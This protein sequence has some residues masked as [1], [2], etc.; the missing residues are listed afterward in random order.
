MYKN[1]KIAALVPAYNEERLIAKTIMGMPDFV[2]H[3]IVVDD[4]SKDKTSEAAKKTKHKHLV[5]IRHEKNTGLGGAIRT[6]VKKA[7]ELGA[8]IGVVMAGDNQM[9]PAYLPSLLDPI[10][11]EG[12][13]FTKQNRFYATEGF[14]NM[15]RHRVFGS[16]MLAFMTR[17][18]S[19]YWHIIDPQNGYVAYGPKVLEELNFEKI[20]NGYAL[21]NDV[22][23]NLNILGMRI[24]EVPGKIVYADEQSDM[25]LWKIVPSFTLF[26]FLG[27]FRRV[28]KKYVLRGF[29]PIAIFYFFGSILFWF[30]LIFGLWAWRKAHLAGV[31]A[32]TGTVMLAALP[33]LMGFEMLLWGLVLDIQ[34]EPR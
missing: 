22:L 5:L 4:Q 25:N 15:P 23:I 1:K 7:K 18:A 11:E 19:G 14:A 30:G 34:E 2:D 10:C 21:E 16:I 28:F 32:T 3:I 17:V 12:Y 27:F 24:K 6:A 8:D 9:D 26:L 31:P 29:H 20:T 13:D 33:F